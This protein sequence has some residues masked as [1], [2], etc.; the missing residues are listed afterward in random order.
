MKKKIAFTKNKWSKLCAYHLIQI[1]TSLHSSVSK[2]YESPFIKEKSYLIICT[3]FVI[4][5][6]TILLVS[7]F[8]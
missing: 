6:R 7:K 4:V 2:P 8:I 5:Y 3:F 1:Y